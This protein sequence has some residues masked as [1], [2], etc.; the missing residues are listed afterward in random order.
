[1]TMRAC[2]CSRNNNDRCRDGS[3]CIS[4]RLKSPWEFGLA[5]PPNFGMFTFNY[6]SE[7]RQVEEPEKVCVGRGILVNMSILILAPPTTYHLVVWVIEVCRQGPQPLIYL[8]FY[9]Y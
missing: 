1:M 5:A 3:A 9:Y 4:E 7:T 6:D 8:V 2:M